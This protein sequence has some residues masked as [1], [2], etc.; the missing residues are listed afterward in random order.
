MLN[1]YIQNDKRGQAGDIRDIIVERKD[2][3]WEIGFSVKHNHEAVKHSRLSDKND[4]SKKWYD[5]K[6][7]KTYWDDVKP[8][9]DLLKAEKQKGTLFDDLTSKEERVYIPILKAFMGELKR[10]IS[11]DPSIPQKMVAY[12]LSKYDFY[13]VI[14]LDRKRVTTVQSFNMYGTLNK[15]SRTKQ[16]DL[17]APA[18]TLPQTLLFMNFKPGSSNTIIMCFENGWQFSFRIHNAEKQVKTSLKFDVR[19]VGMPAEINIKF[20]CNW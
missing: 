13:K 11:T 9:F 6:C 16:A 14:S 2:I 17:K 5:V 18:I 8:V 4:F 12:L 15:P 1:L 19:I 20:N 3:L 10:Q 7:S